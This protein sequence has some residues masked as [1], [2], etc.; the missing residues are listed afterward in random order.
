MYNPLI[1]GLLARGFGR[2]AG[3]FQLEMENEGII[4]LLVVGV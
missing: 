3:A 1:T 4:P 2:K